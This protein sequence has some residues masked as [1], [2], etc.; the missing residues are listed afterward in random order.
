MSQ[1][2]D[3]AL[4]PYEADVLYTGTTLPTFLGTVTRNSRHQRS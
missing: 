1:M 3:V 4:V 2:C